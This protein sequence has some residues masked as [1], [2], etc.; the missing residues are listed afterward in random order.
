M[1]NSP[2]RGLGTNLG[3]R[4]RLGFRDLR[5]L[6][7]P[8]THNNVRPPQATR[9]HLSLGA[10]SRTARVICL[11]PWSGISMRPP[12]TPVF[13]K[14]ITLANDPT[15]T[16][17]HG[18]TTLA[19][20]EVKPENPITSNFRALRCLRNDTAKDTVD[21]KRCQPLPPPRISQ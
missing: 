18:G 12:F 16:R 17:R 19:P 13:T 20:L 8:Q 4:H 14:F 7:L 1:S 5:S 3:L 6:T 21:P 9:T 2:C 15:I 11:V 10:S